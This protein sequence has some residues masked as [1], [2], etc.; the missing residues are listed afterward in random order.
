MPSLFAPTVTLATLVIRHTRSSSF[1]GLTREPIPDRPNM[2]PEGGNP[3]RQKPQTPRALPQTPAEKR[4]I[5]IFGAPYPLRTPSQR[6]AGA[7]FMPILYKSLK[8]GKPSPMRLYGDLKTYGVKSISA[9][10]FVR[11]EFERVARCQLIARLLPIY[12]TASNSTGNARSPII[13]FAKQYRALAVS[14]RFCI[15]WS[16]MDGRVRPAMTNREGVHHG[17]SWRLICATRQR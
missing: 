16:G 9:T 7:F 8:N 12:P 4:R 10:P 3:P 13:P 2:S 5:A 17:R 1:P 15:E 6:P 14:Y 11:I